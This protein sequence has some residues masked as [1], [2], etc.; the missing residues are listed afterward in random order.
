MDNCV[1]NGKLLHDSHV[2]SLDDKVRSYRII[3]SNL[4]RQDIV[5]LES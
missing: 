3:K 1:I 4:V 2:D 5:N